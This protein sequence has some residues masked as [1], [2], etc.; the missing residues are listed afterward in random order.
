MGGFHDLFI[1]MGMADGRPH[2]TQ[3][4]DFLAKTFPND[5]IPEKHWTSAMRSRA[6][7]KPF[8][9]GSNPKISSFTLIDSSGRL[10][11]FLDRRGY[12]RVDSLGTGSR[13]HIQV[14]F[15]EEGHEAAF[16]MPAAQ[17]A[18]V[19]T[20]LVERGNAVS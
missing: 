4:H 9:G 8:E 13:F 6:G 16:E 7:H 3:V 19:S 5:Y 20:G 12:G 1:P 11:K 17:V 10:K 15:A 2:K 14:A 18:M